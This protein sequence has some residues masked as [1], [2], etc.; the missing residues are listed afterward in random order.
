MND[1]FMQEREN[2]TKIHS[3]DIEK[4]K[5]K[6]KHEMDTL[7]ENYQNTI[8]TKNNESRRIRE[9]VAKTNDMIKLFTKQYRQNLNSVKEDYQKQIVAVIGA[10]KQVVQKEKPNV[11]KKKIILIK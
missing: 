6:H 5:A 1:E 10:M 4:I 11:K 7:N 2:I 3:E 9:S 8:R